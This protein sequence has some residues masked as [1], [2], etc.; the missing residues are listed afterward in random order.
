[1]G[2]TLIKYITKYNNCL[3]WNNALCTKNYK[4]SIGRKCTKYCRTEGILSILSVLLWHIKLIY[5]TLNKFSICKGFVLLYQSRLLWHI[6]LRV[7]MTYQTHI[8]HTKKIQ[9]LQG[10]CITL[11]VP[12]ICNNQTKINVQQYIVPSIVHD[13]LGCELIN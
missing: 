10:I 6:I 1:M 5:S 3:I 12:K 2:Q 7:I 8:Q 11:Q 4:I 9:N 13:L